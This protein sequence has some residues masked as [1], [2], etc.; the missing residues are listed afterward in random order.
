MYKVC[1]FL[2]RILSVVFFPMKVVGQK[3][4]HREGRYILAC[5]HQSFLDIPIV[6]KAAAPRVIHFIAKKSLFTKNRLLGWFFRK[7]HAFP[8]DHAQMDMPAVRHAIEV[9]KGEQVLGIF[10]QG[11]RVRTS[12]ALSKDQLFSGVAMIALRAQA[13]IVPCMILERPRLFRRA[14]LIVGDPIRAA[15]YAGQKLKPQLIE[16]L[17]DRIFRQMNGLLLRK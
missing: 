14:T 6:M 17:T 5:N 4:L 9:L 7:V 13:D 8:V 1:I 16:E 12:A 11:T 3:G 15:D 2:I 10:P